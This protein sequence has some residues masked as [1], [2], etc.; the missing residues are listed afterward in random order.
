MATQLKPSSL[1]RIVN[2]AVRYEFSDS[3]QDQPWVLWLKTPNQLEA[4]YAYDLADKLTQRHVTG[5]W[6]DGEQVQENPEAVFGDDGQPLPISERTIFNACLLVVMQDAPQGEPEYN[7]PI[8]IIS[9]IPFYPEAWEKILG[10]LLD[11]RSPKK[12]TT[13]LGSSDKSPDSPSNLE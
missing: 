2:Q 5:N 8:E 3:N 13:D 11:I 7:D 4:A 12:P 6:F 1:K 9:L 10:K